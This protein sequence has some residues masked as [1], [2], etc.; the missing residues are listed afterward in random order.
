M[1]T[2]QKNDDT[3]KNMYQCQCQKLRKIFSRQ[4]H[5]LLFSFTVIS[6]VYSSFIP[7]NTIF[8]K[9]Y[10]THW[11]SKLP[12]VLWNPLSEA[13]PGKFNGSSGHSKCN[14]LQDG[15]DFHRNCP[16]FYLQLPSTPTGIVVGPCTRPSVRPSVPND[17]TTLTLKGFQLS[18]WNLVG[19]CTL[20]WSISLLTMAMLDQFLCVPRNFENWSRS[21][22]RRYRSKSLRILAIGLK[23]DG[24]MHITM[25]H[26][27]VENGHAGPIIA[28]STELFRDK[29][30][31]GVRKDVTAPTL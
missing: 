15:A 21:E 16:N 26:I 6:D 1:M 19:W 10:L 18:V 3:Q 29:L 24:M 20:P 28:R 4:T 9:Y 11:I 13:E 8:T 7:N 27:V 23:F 5:K 17:I 14:C 30:G 22:K 2:S 25:K 31:A 12:G